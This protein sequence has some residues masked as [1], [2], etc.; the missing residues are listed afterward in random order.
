MN[1]V[2]SLVLALIF[3]SSFAQAA[4]QKASSVEVFC[5]SV[6]PKGAIYLN[7]NTQKGKSFG[8]MS[9]PFTTDLNALKAKNPSQDQ[10]NKLNV[11]YAKKTAYGFSFNASPYMLVNNQEVLNLT[12]SHLDLRKTPAVLEMFEDQGNIVLSCEVLKKN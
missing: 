6:S 11:D 4:A 3:T 7:L 12:K 1:A 9:T 10:Y 2:L 8:R 5:L